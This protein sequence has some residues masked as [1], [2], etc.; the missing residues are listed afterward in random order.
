MHSLLAF[1]RHL[2]RFTGWRSLAVLGLMLVAAL[3]E[4]IGLV[5][6]L[7]IM[8][9]AGLGSES[10]FSLGIIDTI[11]DSLSSANIELTLHGLVAV[12]VLLMVFRQLIVYASTRLSENTRIGYVAALREEL[13]GALCDTDW[14]TVKNGGVRHLGQILLVDSWR[15]GDAAQNFFRLGSTL[16]LV[17]VNFAIAA[18]LSPILALSVFFGIGGLTLL[19][20][21][22]YGSV[23]V[24]GSNITRIQND[25]YRVVENYLDSLRVAKLANAQPQMRADFARTVSALTRQ[26]TG[27]VDDFAMTRMTFQ[28]GTAIGV[29]VFLIFAVEIVGA[30]GPELALLVIISARLVPQCSMINQYA[31]HL[32]HQLPAFE[33]VEQALT[34]CRRSTDVRQSKVEPIVPAHSIALRGVETW[35]HGPSKKRLLADINIEIPVGLTVA[36]QGPSGA[37]KSTMADVLSGLLL[38]ET[39]DLLIDGEPVREERLSAW[40]QSVG[41]VP[42]HSVLL[43]DTIKRNLTWLL[44]REPSRQEFDRALACTSLDSMVEALPDGLDTMISRREGALSGGERQRIAIARELLRRPRLLILDEATNALDPDS[45]QQLLANLKREYPGITVLIIAHRPDTIAQADRVIDL[46]GGRV[47]ADRVSDDIDGAGTPAHAEVAAR[48]DQ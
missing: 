29:G 6:L 30:R 35:A 15:V 27:F 33:Q 26:Y 42:Q 39:G 44:A 7:P 41:Y 5:L 1:T 32:L 34:E 47:I 28:I 20:R 37:G 4:G 3:S 14:R 45:E 16:V 9:L 23:Q 24:Q 38:V 25:L 43:E 18:A 31:Q 36:V 13:F 12:F 22:R 11:V 46:D 19:L 48:M 21:K 10:G 2:L 40:R 17:F 8:S